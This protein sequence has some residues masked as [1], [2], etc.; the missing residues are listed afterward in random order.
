ML[1]KLPACVRI[2]MGVCVYLWVCGC[3]L[4]CAYERMFNVTLC[5]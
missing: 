2:C 3:V 1:K 5:V 4:V